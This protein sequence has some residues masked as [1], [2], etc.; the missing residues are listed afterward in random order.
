M[1]GFKPYT[2]NLNGRLVEFERPAVMGII[3]VTPDSFYGGSR[4][5]LA[6]AVAKAGRMLAEG[7]DILDVGGC[8]TRP[9]FAPPDA[10]EELARVVPAIAELR[11]H[12]PQA[13]ISVD[14][15]RAEVAR[16]AIEA[17]ADII[18]DVSGLDAT[19]YADKDMLATVAELNVPYVLT[20][21]F[22][23]N[24]IAL[25]DTAAEVV[26]W[27]QQR[28]NSLTLRGVSDVIVDP[29]F[30][31]GKSVEQ[32]YALLRNLDLLS[33]LGCPVLAAL[34]RKSMIFKRLGITPE[35]SLAGTI[36]LDT[37][38]LMKGAAMLRVHDV[39]PAAQT[40]KLLY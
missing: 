21:S 23:M 3:N 13:V 35:E 37:V 28:L 20:A 33:V 4:V 39:E 22:D 8:S 24:G 10:E 2:L 9:G 36:A 38:A 17:G 34:S 18:N 30:G 16:R 26:K 11:R 15:Y 29:G 12:F 14:T 31:F 6:E 19:E 1:N 25:A 27:L 5:G 7:A 40:V 32:N